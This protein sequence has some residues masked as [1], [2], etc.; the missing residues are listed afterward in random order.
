RYRGIPNSKTVLIDPSYI[1]Q[2]DHPV[3][4]FINVVSDSNAYVPRRDGSDLAIYLTSPAGARSIVEEIL[5]SLTAA[6][7]II[8][9]VVLAPEYKYL[10]D[11]PYLFDDDA[12]GEN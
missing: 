11:N 4:E 5:R 8:R 9:F 10:I 2:F 3:D 6:G 1:F 7:I 12:P